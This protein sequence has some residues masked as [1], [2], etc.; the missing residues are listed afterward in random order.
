MAD[1]TEGEIWREGRLFRWL[2]EVGR[3]TLGSY[4]SA[5][6]TGRCS[7]GCAA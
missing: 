1:L 2:D 6:R 4:I 5:R 3:G 7:L